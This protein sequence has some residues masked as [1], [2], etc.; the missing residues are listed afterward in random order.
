MN[1]LELV[2]YLM[3]I[4]FCLFLTSFILFHIKLYMTR[5]YK[6]KKEGITMIN[7]VLNSHILR[8]YFSYSELFLV[9]ESLIPQKHVIKFKLMV[10]IV[11]WFFVIACSI[12]SICVLIV[13]NY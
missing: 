6:A 4:A 2:N 7:M 3:K 1:K 9:D 11:I 10:K 13:H 12:S 8:P 5:F